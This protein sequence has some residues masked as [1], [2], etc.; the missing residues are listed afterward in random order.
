MRLR[1]SSIKSSRICLITF[2]VQSGSCQALL[3]LLP[4]RKTAR[5][6]DCAAMAAHVGG[7]D[8]LRYT[9]R[10][11]PPGRTGGLYDDPILKQLPHMAEVRRADVEPRPDTLQSAEDD[12]HACESVVVGRLALCSR[13][14]RRSGGIPG[15]STGGL[16]GTG[17]GAAGGSGASGGL[18]GSSA[19]TIRLQI[20]ANY[21]LAAFVDSQGPYSNV[22]HCTRISAFGGSPDPAVGY[23]WTY[24]LGDGLPATIAI[25]PNTGLFQGTISSSFAPGPPGV[26]DGASTIYPPDR[27]RCSDGVSSVSSAAGGIRVFVQQ[28]FSTS[29]GA[30]NCGQDG[31]ERLMPYPQGPPLLGSGYND[32]EG[33]ASAPRDIV[34]DLNVTSIQVNRPFG[35]ALNFW[36]GVPPY[37]FQLSSG[38]LPPGLSLTASSGEIL[39]TPTSAAVS[40]TYSFAVTIA[41]GG[42]SSSQY[43]FVFSRFT[44]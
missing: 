36:G 30:Y 21:N 25:D 27:H 14:R 41:D 17:Q 35:Y 7:I 40:N 3:A 11:D 34:S 29:N 6:A 9:G 33:T 4:I 16:G 26:A 10:A 32:S 15:T 31:V 24:V 23:S 12:E 28:C 43:Y 19:S 38:A 18:G 39:G 20:D 44:T 1:T 42:G 8:L 37:T 2:R 5:A 22:Q 13:V